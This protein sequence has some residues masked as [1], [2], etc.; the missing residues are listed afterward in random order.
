MKIITAPQEMSL[1]PGLV[2]RTVV[3][4]RMKLGMSLISLSYRRIPDNVAPMLV[5]DCFNGKG[6]L[7]TLRYNLPPDT[8]KRTDRRISLLLHLLHKDLAY[9]NDA[10]A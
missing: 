2:T 8:R 6:K 7:Y 4:V 1:S 5:I 9:E 3:D 10:V